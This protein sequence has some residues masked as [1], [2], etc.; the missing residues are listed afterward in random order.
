[1]M[2]AYISALFE[3]VAQTASAEGKTFQE[4]MQ[5]IAPGRKLDAKFPRPPY[6]DVVLRQLLNVSAVPGVDTNLTFDN[7][8]VPIVKLT[9]R[10]PVAALLLRAHEATT[11]SDAV[12]AEWATCER[13]GRSFPKKRSDERGCSPKCKNYLKV[14]RHRDR[15]VLQMLRQPQISQ[16]VF[17]AT[18]QPR[19]A[20]RGQP[21]SGSQ[22]RL[23]AEA[24]RQPQAAPQSH[25]EKC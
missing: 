7:D 10:D 18:N 8:G 12:R 9:A 11:L 2:G 21:A 22:G 5:G 20:H 3:A 16:A 14:K 15:K 25:P 23:A 1:M 4:V 17:R 24:T 13:C 19:Q 6:P